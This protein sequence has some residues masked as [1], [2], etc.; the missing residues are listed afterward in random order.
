MVQ[1]LWKC[2]AEANALPFRLADRFAWKCM[3]AF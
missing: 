2:K 1:T 3:E